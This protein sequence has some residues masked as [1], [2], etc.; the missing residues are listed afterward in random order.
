[1]TC[2]ANSS[3]LSSN[4]I[5]VDARELQTPE[6]DEKYKIQFVKEDPVAYNTDGSAE[7]SPSPTPHITAAHFS[8]SPPKSISVVYNPN[9][10]RISGVDNEPN[11][12]G[13]YVDKSQTKSAHGEAKAPSH[14]IPFSD[15]DESA[16]RGLLALGSS[17]SL[18]DT[19]PTVEAPASVTNFVPRSTLSPLITE[20]PV[21]R[22]GTSPAAP[23]PLF[24]EMGLPS[25][26]EPFSPNAAPIASVPETRKLELLRHYQ[27]H[28]APWLDLSDMTRPFGL[29][30][31]DI[32]VKSNILIHAVMEL[33][34]ACATQQLSDREYQS[35]PSFSSHARQLPPNRQGTS[36]NM[37]ST[38]LSLFILLDELRALVS[39]IPTAWKNANCSDPRLQES[40][41]QHAYGT[42]IESVM[43]WM[44]LRLE[45]DTILA[46]PS[47]FAGKP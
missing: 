11:P 3:P 37:N 16:I 31:V 6:T 42:D 17:A 36:L 33:S 2:M 43:Y 44:F 45:F 10:R 27:Y 25:A 12:I 39:N 19:S 38:E 5:T 46:W 15:K 30:V 9:D 41:V 32:A 26:T 20:T 8:S 24:R 4:S 47:G 34:N 28:V 14:K 1:M 18:N 40:L 21:Q 7:D 13:H 35:R 23:Y 22:E 29:T